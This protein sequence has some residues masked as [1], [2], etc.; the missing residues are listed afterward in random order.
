MKRVGISR[1]TKSTPAGFARSLV[2]S[3]QKLIVEIDSKFDNFPMSNVLKR[4]L[5]SLNL[6]VYGMRL[7]CQ[8][9]MY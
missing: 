4:L 6:N 8:Q 7:A 5:T 2:L 3:K 9:T 1:E